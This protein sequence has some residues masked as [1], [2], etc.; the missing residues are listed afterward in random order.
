MKT[1]EQKV[2]AYDEALERARLSRL[3]LLDIGEEATE[4]EYIFPELKE[5]SEDE[6]I[7]K[8]IIKYLEQTVP[9]NHRDDVLKSKEWIA[10][11]EKQGIE[12]LLSENEYE[13]VINALKEG[14]KYHQLFNP[15]FGG[16]PCI[17]IVNWLEKQ[18]EQKHNCGKDDEKIIKRIDSLLYAINE[19][20]FEDIHAW[21]KCLKDKLQSQSQWK[22]S[23][24]QLN[25]LKQ[26]INAFPYETDYLELLY[27]DLKKLKGE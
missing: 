21:L 14:F 9:H 25:T 16:I 13:R 27:D 3:Q 17:E 20:E 23:D 22:P 5:E 7:S 1:I 4:I 6:R 24:E 19:N 15:T 26:A 8:E 10:W 2:K 11:L 12:K 18:S